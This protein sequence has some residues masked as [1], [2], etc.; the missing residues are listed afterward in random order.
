[1]PIITRADLE[2]RLS[3]QDVAQLA[4]LDGA[5]AEA[6]GMVDACIAD[7][8]A[9]VL[10]FVRVAFR[11]PLPDPAPD[12]LKRLTVDVARYNLYQRHVPDD[13]PVAIAYRVAISMLRDIASGRICLGIDGA[14]AGGI[15][16]G[17]APPR[18][19]T[20][21]AMRGMMP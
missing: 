21:D 8:Q 12:L 1:M 19:M 11:G 17:Y 18:V 7:A 10:G 2:S 16:V 5:N 15:D 14:Q 13:H 9:E 3:P 20:D 6:P 4:D